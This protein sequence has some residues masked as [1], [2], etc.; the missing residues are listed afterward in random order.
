MVRALEEYGC[1]AMGSD[2]HDYGCGYGV[3]DFLFDVTWPDDLGLHWIITNPPY[4]LAEQFAL[5]ALA[6][7]PRRG[8]ALLMRSNWR[9]NGGRYTRLFTEHPPTYTYDFCDRL[10]MLRGRCAQR[11]ESGN[12]NGATEYA[13]FVWRSHQLGQ[14]ANPPEYIGRWIPPGT[15][16]RLERAS[17]YDTT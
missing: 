14:P 15:R 13:W 7:R 5:K 9:A 16:K 4:R 17:D 10:L 3:E 6:L 2:V 11:G 8:V 1:L 12:T